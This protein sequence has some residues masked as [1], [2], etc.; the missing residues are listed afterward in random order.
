MTQVQKIVQGQ[1]DLFKGIYK[2][3]LEEFSN[4]DLLSFSLFGDQQENITQVQ[5][6]CPFFK[7]VA[8]DLLH[9]KD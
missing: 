7:M 8:L 1:F 5:Q 9:L 2:P 6:R 4:K 3:V